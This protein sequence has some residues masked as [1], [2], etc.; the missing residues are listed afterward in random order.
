MIWRKVILNW[1][2]FLSSEAR[3]SIQFFHSVI[4]SRL[5]KCTDDLL[6]EQPSCSSNKPSQ[7]VQSSLEYDIGKIFDNADISSIIDHEKYK[8]LKY[9][10]KP[11][12]NFSFPKKILYICNRSWEAENLTENLGSKNSDSAFVYAVL[13]LPCKNQSY[14]K[15]DRVAKWHNI[16]EKQ[17]KNT[18]II[19][20]T[21]LLWQMV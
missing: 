16:L 14:H 21:K 12:V 13:Y 2:F 5:V 1:N 20:T 18:D 6:L 10:F 11:D 3:S 8:I 9:N 17:H 7:V 4:N 15:K 19:L